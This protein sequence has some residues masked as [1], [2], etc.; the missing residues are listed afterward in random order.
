MSQIY[1]SEVAVGTGRAIVDG[2]GRARDCLDELNTSERRAVA[3]LLRIQQD[4]AER[5]ANAFGVIPQPSGV[6]SSEQRHRITPDLVVV[7]RN[8][9]VAIEIDGGQHGRTRA[10]DALR[11]RLIG[12]SGLSVARIH[13]RDALDDYHL[14][15]LLER[16]ILEVSGHELRS[17]PLWDEV[18]RGC[19]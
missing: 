18:T 7:G 12:R 4:L 6:W 14:A 10:G 19:A 16:P 17:L 15:C 11:D 5:H 13:W 1:D 8:G 2:R 3:L 9:G